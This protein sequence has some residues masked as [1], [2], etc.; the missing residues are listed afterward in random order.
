MAGMVRKAVADGCDGIALNIIDATAFDAVVA[1][2][3]RKS[4][5]V[6]AVNVYDP[7]VHKS[8]QAPVARAFDAKGALALDH[9]GLLAGTVLFAG[10][11]LQQVVACAA[12]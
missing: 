9:E 12:K 10:A 4:V 7:A 8:S 5:P 11:T 3:V 2:A 6:V 1:E